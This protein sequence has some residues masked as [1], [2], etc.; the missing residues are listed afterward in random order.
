M[1]GKAGKVG[2]PEVPVK[3]DFECLTHLSLSLVFSIFM[4]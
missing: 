3:H 4:S 2:S 1:T